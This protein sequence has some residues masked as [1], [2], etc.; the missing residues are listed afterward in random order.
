M[1]FMEGKTQ[2]IDLLGAM[3]MANQNKQRQQGGANDDL[4]R[5]LMQQ[6]LEAAKWNLE[7]EKGAA[8][9]SVVP[10]K[11]AGML[12]GE[13]G[14]FLSTRQPLNQMPGY[15]TGTSPEAY[16]AQQMAIREALAHGG[17]VNSVGGPTESETNLM[18][19]QAGLAEEQAKSLGLKNK[20][21]GSATESRIAD[22]L[23]NAKMQGSN[24][25]QYDSMIRDLQGASRDRWGDIKAG[26]KMISDTRSAGNEMRSEIEAT[27]KGEARAA[28]DAEASAAKSKIESIKTMA[29]Q[30]KAYSQLTNPEQAMKKLDEFV[31]WADDNGRTIDKNALEKYLSDLAAQQ[32]G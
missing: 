29:R 9:A 12:T 24:D 13:F 28:K 31:H 30:T 10:D 32:K 22:V 4:Q 11:T 21:Y 20:G 16:Q 25:R 27:Q 17:G 26:D 3:Q 8:T 23:A 7:K 19:Q 15:V 5:R 18:N 1:A 2:L 6:Q 14:N